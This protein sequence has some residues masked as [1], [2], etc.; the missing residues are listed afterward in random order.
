[1]RKGQRFG[2]SG[3]CPYGICASPLCLFAQPQSRHWQHS[4]HPIS[5][6]HT[7]PYP[8]STKR[9]QR[10]KIIVDR[11]NCHP[12]IISQKTLIPY[13][14]RRAHLCHHVLI[15]LPS[16]IFLHTS[17]ISHLQRLKVLCHTNDVYAFSCSPMRVKVRGAGIDAFCVILTFTIYL[18]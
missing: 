16:Y 1:M 3:T 9:P 18:E 6:F 15:H 13:R 4:A 2:M 14:T 11:P 17:S 12:T 5:L 8:A 10:Y 7:Q